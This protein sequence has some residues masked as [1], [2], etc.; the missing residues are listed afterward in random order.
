MEYCLICPENKGIRTYRYSQIHSAYLLGARIFV[1]AVRNS[2]PGPGRVAGGTARPAVTRRC[3]DSDAAAENLRV[4]KRAHA[5]DVVVVV[6]VIRFVRC[7]RW[8]ERD[9]SGTGQTIHGYF[10]CVRAR[11]CSH[12]LCISF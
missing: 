4:G 3:I 10:R 11:V 9:R 2:L 1:S 7:G 6:V 5:L 12:V 8:P